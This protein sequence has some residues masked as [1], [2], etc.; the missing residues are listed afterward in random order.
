[1]DCTYQLLPLCGCLTNNSVHSE[2]EHFLFHAYD[3]HERGQFW[4]KFYHLI[5]KSQNSWWKPPKQKCISTEQRTGLDHSSE[6]EFQPITNQ[7]GEG[8]PML[9]TWSAAR[10][11]GLTSWWWQCCHSCF[12]QR[13]NSAEIGSLE[14]AVLTLGIRIHNRMG[15][16]EQIILILLRGIWSDCREMENRSDIF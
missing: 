12:P 4:A 10:K 14:L 5:R 15:R 16:R 3:C 9:A 13:W 2:S 7:R 11:G 6:K 8:T 1:M